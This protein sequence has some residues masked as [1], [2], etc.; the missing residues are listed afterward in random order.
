VGQFEIHKKEENHICA[1][2][3]YF[4]FYNLC[5]IL[6]TL[7]VTPAMEARLTDYVWGVEEIV[8]LLESK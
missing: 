2:A 8:S 1:V 4:M 5:R 3:M 6:Q 7:R